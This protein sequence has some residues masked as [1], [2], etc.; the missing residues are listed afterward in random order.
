MKFTFFERREYGAA[1]HESERVNTG[2]E[3]KKLY[4]PH[5]Y[6]SIK[7]YIPKAIDIIVKVASGASGKCGLSD[8]HCQFSDRIESLRK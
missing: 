2:V 8:S 7:S 4:N 6:S 1:L 5:L 3:V